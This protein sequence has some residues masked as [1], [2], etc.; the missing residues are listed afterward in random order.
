MSPAENLLLLAVYV[1]SEVVFLKAGL[2]TYDI[3]EQSI[4]PYEHIML[5]Q[6]I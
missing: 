2:P 3:A 6:P 4:L 5:V 1:G